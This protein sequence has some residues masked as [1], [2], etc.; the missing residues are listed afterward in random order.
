MTAQLLAREPQ[1]GPRGRSCTRDAQDGLGRR[2]R[3]DHRRTP[4]TA[5]RRAAV[6]DPAFA[7]E[8]ER[9][10]EAAFEAHRGHARVDMLDARS[11]DRRRPG[12]ERARQRPRDHSA[13]L[14]APARRRRLSRTSPRGVAGILGRTVRLYDSLSRELRGGRP[15]RAGAREDLLVRPD[16]VPLH[17]HRQ[18]AL[19]HAGRPDPARRCASRARTSAGS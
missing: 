6:Q 19:V 18:H 2:R 12:F 17:P 5:R 4:G 13:R 8:M 11:R 15:G 14:A 7:E 1:R 3:G 16:R 10:H 9:Y